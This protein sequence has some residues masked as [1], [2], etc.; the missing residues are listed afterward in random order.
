VLFYTTRESRTIISTI[1]GKTLNRLELLQS[2]TAMAAIAAV[3]RAKP[4]RGGAGVPEGAGKRL[5]WK[6]KGFGEPN[7]FLSEI[8]LKF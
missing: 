3:T 7:P 4:L 6:G 5:G 2:A 1:G 8:G